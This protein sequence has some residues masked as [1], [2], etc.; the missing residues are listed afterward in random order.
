MF[1]RYMRYAPMIVLQ[2]PTLPHALQFCNFAVFV[3][4]KDSIE[5]VVAFIESIYGIVAE[6]A[7][8]G[9]AGADPQK[10]Q[11]AQLLHQHVVKV[12]PELVQ[13]IFQLM[14]GL[15]TRYV[16]DM[17]PS[18]LESIRNAFGREQFRAWVEASFHKLPPS[19]ASNSERIN[20]QRQLVEGDSD[21]V[22]EAVRDLCYRC[23]QVV[24][25]NRNKPEESRSR[26]REK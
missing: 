19:V 22:Y 12:S 9:Q 26:Q 7:N 23:E 2:A 3:Q 13:A 18:V 6:C 21:W 4:Q 24:L 10:M 17:I 8:G 16:Q 5:A 15:P 20:F 11:Q 25:R 14:A 1:E